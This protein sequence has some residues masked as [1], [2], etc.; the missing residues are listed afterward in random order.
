MDLA[1]TIPGAAALI[2]W[3][4]AAALYTVG[5]YRLK[6]NLNQFGDSLGIVGLVTAAGGATWLAW[7]A[8]WDLALIQSSLT[9]GVAVS[10]LVVYA[11]LA[12]QR[13]ERLSALAMLIFAIPIQAVAMGQLFGQTAEVFLPDTLLPLWMPLRTLTGLVGY[14]GLAVSAMMVLLIFALARI[15]ERL[16]VDHLAAG[17]GL[18]A[19]EWRSWQIALVAL[20]ISVSIGLIRTWWG[21]GQVMLGGNSWTMVTWLLV[22]AS[23]VGLMQGATRA[24]LAR[25]L[26]VLACVVGVFS[27][28]TVAGSLARTG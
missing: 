13:R 16:S 9:S 17:I 3:F 21:T 2:V 1:Y 12:H 14:G 6:P 23:A 11:L 20:S 5:W 25:V 8:P 24:R 10:A 15:K 19:L 22:A 28:L 26:V 7:D 4:L 27:I 18:R